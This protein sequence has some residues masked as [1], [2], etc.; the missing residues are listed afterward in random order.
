MPCSRGCCLDQL[1]H[2]QSIGISAAALPTRKKPVIAKLR[3]DENF[4]KDG[5]AYKRLVKQGYQP[6]HIDGCAE[7]EQRAESRLEVESMKILSPEKKRTLET[8]TN[9]SV[10]NMRYHEPG[11]LVAT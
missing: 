2:Y 6:D 4:A 1:S 8:L 3:S 9:N 11:G 10:D 5:P 7:I